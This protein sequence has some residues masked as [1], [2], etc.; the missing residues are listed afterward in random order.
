MKTQVHR[1]EVLIVD[2]DDVGPDGVRRLL[3]HTRYP[4]RAISPHVMGIETRAVDWS[5]E[6]PLNRAATTEGA[7]RELFGERAAE[8]VRAADALAEAVRD[9][10]ALDM[11]EDDPSHRD[12][13]RAVY[14]AARRYYAASTRSAR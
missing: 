7:Y 1:V 11:H 6:H 14:D 13:V 5:D 2:T 9:C 8:V 10:D 3:E 12:G 4:N